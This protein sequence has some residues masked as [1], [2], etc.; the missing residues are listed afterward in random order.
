MQEQERALTTE[1]VEPVFGDALDVDAVAPQRCDGI[2]GRRE[3]RV[4]KIKSLVDAGFLSK[5]KRRDDGGRRVAAIAQ[6]F[7][8]QSLAVRDGEA[9]A[10]AYA[11]I[12]RQTAGQQ[13]DA[14][15]ATSA[16]YERYA[17]SNT[18]PSAASASMRGR[19]HAS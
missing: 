12:E 3:V 19:L 10:V 13:G 7:R 14:W 11:G 4:E 5:Q 1:R 18:T 17:R 6:H 8:Q 16:E 2:V 15:R 9:H